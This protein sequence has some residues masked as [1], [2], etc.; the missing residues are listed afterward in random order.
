MTN[1]KKLLKAYMILSL[2]LLKLTKNNLIYNNMKIYK[3]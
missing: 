2:Y 1:V 3:N